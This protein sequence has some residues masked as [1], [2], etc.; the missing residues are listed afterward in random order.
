MSQT[1]PEPLRPPVLEEGN[2][3]LLR[4]KPEAC[5]PETW[6]TVRFIGFTPCPAVVII[7]IGPGRRMPIARDDLFLAA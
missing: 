4:R 7:A 2:Q 5:Q 6:E 1:Q 3:Y